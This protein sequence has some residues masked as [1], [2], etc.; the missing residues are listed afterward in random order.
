V[1]VFAT[2]NFKDIELDWS[3]NVIELGEFRMK[4]RSISSKIILVYTMYMYVHRYDVGFLEN[5]L[6]FLCRDSH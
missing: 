3:I 2:S 1:K 5:D 6:K 4:C